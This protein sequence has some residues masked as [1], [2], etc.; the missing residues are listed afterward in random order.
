VNTT[1]YIKVEKLFEHLHFTKLSK[2][3]ITVANG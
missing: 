1:I 3:L 2:L